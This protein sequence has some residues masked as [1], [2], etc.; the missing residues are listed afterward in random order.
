MKINNFTFELSENYDESKL[1][2]ELSQ[3]FN[4]EKGPVITDKIIIYDTFGWQFFAK[5]LSLYQYR[6]RLFL[7]NIS[8]DKII[9]S[10]N[11]VHMPVF[12][13]D[14]PEGDLKQKISLLMK[15]RAL[16]EMAVIY[17]S[18]FSY[19][20][21][22]K[23][24]KIVARIILEKYATS[25]SLPFFSSWLIVQ[26]VRGYSK[27]FGKLANLCLKSGI[28]TRKKQDIYFKAL[29]AV[30]NKPGSYSNKFLIK[31]KP[32][33]RTDTAVKIIL[34]ALLNI[35]KV[36]E[37]NI[38]KDFDTE[39]LHDFRVAVRKT[40]SVLT[41]VKNVFDPEIANRFKE[42]FRSIG[43]ATNELRDLDVYLLNE[44]HYQTMLPDLLNEDI[45]PLFDYLKKKRSSALK[46]VINYLDSKTYKKIINDWDQFLNQPFDSKESGFSKTTSD[47]KG[48]LLDFNRQIKSKSLILKARIPIIDRSCKRIYKIYKDILKK[49]KLCLE[50]MQDEKLH[51]LRIQCKKLRYLMEFF[52]S[53]FPKKKINILIDQ[54]KSL[55]DHLGDF[56]DLCVE[57]EYLMD[58]SDKLFFSGNTKSSKTIIA[59]GSLVSSLDKEKQKVKKNFSKVFACYA[60]L[61]NKKLFQALFLKN[62]GGL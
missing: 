28:K 40:R 14:F 31:L 2:D 15:K 55:Q 3:V 18:C 48:N 17:C 7:K 62:K 19:A 36:N 52:S 56:N 5:S 60:S 20:V 51:E 44:K 42:D 26:P 10:M 1:L 21:L 53:L 43:K 30:N 61:A 29:K 23:D 38:P 47:I 54:F 57:Q 11:F 34:R 32:L 59:I 46:R 24:E 8:K 41:Q 25:M 35:I 6:S 13:D 16:L 12:I 27:V 39:I 49:G 58:I 4:L 9:H 45:K 33:M 50:D 22:N 37:T